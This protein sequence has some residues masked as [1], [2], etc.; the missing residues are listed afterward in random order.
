MSSLTD[1]IMFLQ[2]S[3]GMTSNPKVAR[4]DDLLYFGGG[5]TVTETVW[6]CVAD[7]CRKFLTQSKVRC[8][9]CKWAFCS[10]EC[11]EGHRDRHALFCGK[12]REEAE[13]RIND[14]IKERR[15][16]VQKEL[17]R[18]KR[19]AKR[20]EK[21][22]RKHQQTRM[23]VI[24][25]EVGGAAVIVAEDVVEEEEECPICLAPLGAD[26]HVTTCSHKFHID[27]W[28]LLEVN[29]YAGR[30]NWECPMCRTVIINHD[31]R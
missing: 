30:L 14:M 12:D 3:V 24:E 11:M 2:E 20:R 1:C 13:A 26:L 27:C 10:E 25:K 29:C 19:N 6:M 21:R 17:K 22:S 5:K 31:T 23:G 7:D 16:S 8:T 15:L 18:I 28:H 4:E 9:K